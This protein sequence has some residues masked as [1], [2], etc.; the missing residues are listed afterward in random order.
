[1]VPG[2]YLDK[3]VR[4]IRFEG[5]KPMGRQH[6]HLCLDEPEGGK[7][8]SGMRANCNVAIW[9]DGQALLEAGVEILRAA[10]GVLLVAADIAPN[11]FSL[12][13]WR[14]P[15]RERKHALW[16]DG[17]DK[18]AEAT[19][20]VPGLHRALES[21]GLLQEALRGDDAR[22]AARGLR[23]SGWISLAVSVLKRDGGFFSGS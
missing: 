3:W 6:I 8:V 4:W 9:V 21:A 13:E 18:T 10:N 7:V 17:Q 11:Y 19:Q 5:L 12:V 14:G 2:T 15:P 20:K 16:A 23:V 1:M 22:G